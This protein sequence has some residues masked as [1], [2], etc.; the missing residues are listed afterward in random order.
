MKILVEQG[1]IDLNAK[2]NVYFNNL[3]FQNSIWNFFKLFETALI[4][5][6]E[7][8]KAIKDKDLTITNQ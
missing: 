8:R 7:K 2:D 5:A 4:F 6:I 3:K 1:R